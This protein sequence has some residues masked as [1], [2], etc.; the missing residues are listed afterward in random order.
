MESGENK[1]ASEVQFGEAEEIDAENPD[2]TE[3]TPLLDLQLDASDKQAVDADASTT[4]KNAFRESRSR[5]HSKLD[6]RRSVTTQMELTNRQSSKVSSDQQQAQESG[7]SWR[8]KDAENWKNLIPSAKMA[9]RAMDVVSNSNHL[10]VFAKIIERKQAVFDQEMEAARAAAEKEGKGDSLANIGPKYRPRLRQVSWVERKAHLN[11]V[12]ASQME[13]HTT[14]EDAIPKLP[15]AYPGFLSTAH[16]RSEGYWRDLLGLDDGSHGRFAF[17]HTPEWNNAVAISI[18]LGAVLLAWDFGVHVPLHFQLAVQ[19]IVVFSL[20]EQIL[21][22]VH[23]LGGATFKHPEDKSVIVLDFMVVTIVAIEAIIWPFFGGQE[24][25][26]L[27]VSRLA[28]LGRFMRL[29]SM[30]PRLREL[31]LGVMEALQGLLW[32]IV[33]LLFFMYALSVVTTRLIGGDVV[34]GPMEDSSEDVQEERKM[35]ISVFTSMFYLFQTTTQWSLV[36]LLPMLNASPLARLFFTCFYI[37]S[38]WVLVAVMTGAVSFTMIA[39][40]ARLVNDDELIDEQ[41]RMMVNEVLLE[42]FTSL[43]E[44]GNGELTHDEF[45]QV[46]YSRELQQLLANNT[47]IKIEDL[48]DM[49]NWLD[50]DGSGSVTIEEFF[51]GFELLNEPF[52]QKTLLRLQERIAKEVELTTKRLNNL[53]RARM[54]QTVSTIYTPLNKIHAV[55]EQVQILMLT[56]QSLCTEVG[57]VWDEADEELFS[58]DLYS[59]ELLGSR[60]TSRGSTM[61]RGISKRGSTAGPPRASSVEET[62]RKRR[63]TVGGGMDNFNTLLG[64]VES[65]LDAQIAEALDRISRFVANPLGH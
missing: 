52:R 26:G 14:Y 1:R 58:E 64:S 15:K 35:F 61:E 27:Q 45:R 50:S 17:L 30:V 19:G 6:V 41:K 48:E 36:P 25:T 2:P 63:Y 34:L 7:G 49:W 38:A 31:T 18:C 16:L 33:F 28:W 54:D 57:K 40:K 62:A 13:S 23:Y 20:V 46:M 53:V 8:P 21:Q 22:A 24:T 47:D 65:R 5:S 4:V 10:A 51:D 29:L 59:Q 11:E 9:R 60:A 12:R 42:I 37:Y 56:A 55:L 39:F 32:I 43:D 44:D 3:S